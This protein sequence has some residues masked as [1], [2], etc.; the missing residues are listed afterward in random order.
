MAETKGKL[1]QILDRLDKSKEYKSDFIKDCAKYYRQYRGKFEKV[2]KGRAHIW[3]P[4]TFAIIESQMPRFIGNRP[5]VE[6]KPL[7]KGRP[8]YKEFSRIVNEKFLYDWVQGKMP[9]RMIPTAK[10]NLLFGFVGAYIPWLYKARRVRERVPLNFLGYDLPISFP[11]TREKVLFEGPVA[12]PISPWRL[13]WDPEGVDVESCGWM[14]HM[15]RVSKEKVEKA[16][17]GDVW[18]VKDRDEKAK[19]DGLLKKM[20]K[21]ERLYVYYYHEDDYA[22][23]LLHAGIEDGKD[24]DIFKTHGEVNVEEFQGVSGDSGPW[25]MVNEREE[26]F[27]DGEK[28]YVISRNVPM[29]EELEGMGD[30]ELIKPQQ[31]ELNI[32]RSL[33]L[34]N[35][36][37]SINRMWIINRSANI[38]PAELQFRPNGLIYV[39]GMPFDQALKE[40]TVSDLKGAGLREEEAVKKDMYAATGQ[41][42][43]RL[44]VETGRNER[45]ATALLQ[46]QEGADVRIRMKMQIFEMEFLEQLG[47]KYLSRNRQFITENFEFLSEQGQQEQE[48]VEIAPRHMQIGYKPIVHGRSTEAYNKPLRVQDITTFL[49]ILRGHPS[50]AERFDP[51]VL[52]KEVAERFEMDSIPGLT[53]DKKEVEQ[54][55]QQAAE[56]MQKR[57]AGGGEVNGQQVLNAVGGAQ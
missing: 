55:R 15:D 28:P 4:Y 11:Q 17:A 10:M 35:A 27:D 57:L 32:L 22:A 52:A 26:P 40:L 9:I 3:V 31:K 30:A 44:G 6:Y 38:D 48:W 1:T 33:R 20:D 23:I 21:W 46:A 14:G 7:V 34:D 42:E 45:T 36:N 25:F 49:N 2:I 8:E 51:D 24:S 54:R 53:F 18:K 29:I 5:R 13:Y 56:M 19:L 12:L 16:L 47:Y 50:L 41:W 43:S 39:N 37:A